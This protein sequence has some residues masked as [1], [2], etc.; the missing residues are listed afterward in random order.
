MQ[1]GYVPGLCREH[2]SSLTCFPINR[3]PCAPGADWVL[4]LQGDEEVTRLSKIA[5]FGS[6]GEVFNVAE[7]KKQEHDH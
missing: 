4:G 2:T 1:C 6:G 3:K 7:I 5:L